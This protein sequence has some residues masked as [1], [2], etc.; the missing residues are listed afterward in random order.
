MKPVLATV[1]AMV[2]LAIVSLVVLVRQLSV[3]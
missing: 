1:A 3:D 2:L